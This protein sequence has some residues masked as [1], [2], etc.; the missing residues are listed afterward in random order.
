MKP[1]SR[2]RS[3]SICGPPAEQPAAKTDADDAAIRR[4]RKTKPEKPCPTPPREW[5][6]WQI[7]QEYFIDPNFGGALI[8]GR[9]NVFDATLD[10]MAPTFLTSPR[11]IAPI[12]SRMR[13]EAID[14]LRVQWDLDYDT[15]A[16][17]IRRGQSLRGLQLW[18]HHSGH[19]PRAAER[20]RRDRVSN[21][22]APSTT[23][24]EPAVAALS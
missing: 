16:R 7:A 1:A 15:I 6:T 19:R 9:R 11:N 3:G 21:G 13:F 14:N 23:H 20:R 4:R 8:P 2:S 5:A 12:T 10:L 17:A 18:P 22:A 24:Q